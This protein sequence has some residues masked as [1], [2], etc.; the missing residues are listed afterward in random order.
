MPSHAKNGEI[1]E[2][3]IYICQTPTHTRLLISKGNDAFARAHRL[4]HGK[5]GV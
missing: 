1:I 2:N 3:I 4:C 5:K